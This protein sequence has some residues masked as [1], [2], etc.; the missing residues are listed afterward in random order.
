MDLLKY[1][2][3]SE[4]FFRPEAD[5]YEGKYYFT[6]GYKFLRDD[7]GELIPCEA[8]EKIENH[9]SDSDLYQCVFES[10]KYTTYG[11]VYFDHTGDAYC[12][13]DDCTRVYLYD[14]DN[15]KLAKIFKQY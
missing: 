12:E 10:K 7:N 4:K 3:C 6:D 13:M 1:T 5:I 11:I 15:N 9:F 2:D 14:H 8:M